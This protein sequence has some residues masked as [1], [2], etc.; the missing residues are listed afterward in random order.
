MFILTTWMCFSCIVLFKLLVPKTILSRHA[1]RSCLLSVGN[2]FSTAYLLYAVQ[3]L[4]S[5]TGPRSLFPPFPAEQDSL[6]KYPNDQQV[7]EENEIHADMLFMCFK[8]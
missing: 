6:P 5:L 2:A 8:I 3:Q 1:K 4:A 7:V